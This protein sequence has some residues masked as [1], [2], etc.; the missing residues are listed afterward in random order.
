[1]P[2]PLLF[3]SADGIDERWVDYNIMRR[4]LRINA[5]HSLHKGIGGHQEL[6]RRHAEKVN[7][8]L[9]QNE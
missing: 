6:C 1:M 9:R 7:R 5:L 3:G 8:L 4:P 2:L